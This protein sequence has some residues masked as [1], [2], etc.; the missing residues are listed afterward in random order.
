M[1]VILVA[2]HDST[3]AFEAADA[4]IALAAR[5][6]ARLRAVA[7]VDPEPVTGGPHPT[8]ALVHL[9]DGADAALRHVVRVADEASVP[10]TTTRRHGRI[11]REILA[12][13][14]ECSADLVV[15]AVVDRP[16]HAIPRVGSHTLRVLEHAEVPVVVVPPRI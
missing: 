12:E 3:A 1:T 7:V 9:E 15:M 8:T 4:A 5:L 10:A 13:A 11:A 2:V 14:R 6:G 16:G